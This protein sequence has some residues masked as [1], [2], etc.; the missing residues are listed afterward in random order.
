M[1]NRYS[2]ILKKN[3]IALILLKTFYVLKTYAHYPV[4][5]KNSLKKNN[6]S[7]PISFRPGN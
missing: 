4:I 6:N 7:K 1:D 2:F 5:Y 3:S